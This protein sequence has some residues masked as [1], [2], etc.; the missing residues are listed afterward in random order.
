[1]PTLSFESRYAHFLLHGFLNFTFFVRENL[2][3]LNNMTVINI[4]GVLI[5][6]CVSDFGVPV[7]A[8]TR[9]SPVHRAEFLMPEATARRPV[10]VLVSSLSFLPSCYQFASCRGLHLSSRAAVLSL[11]SSI[12]FL[13]GKFRMLFSSLPM[14]NFVT[15]AIRGL[16]AAVTLVTDMP[17]STFFPQELA[18]RPIS[19]YG[20]RPVISKP[21]PAQWK[22]NLQRLIVDLPA[23][24]ITSF[25]LPE[26]LFY[27][28][29]FWRERRNKPIGYKIFL[30]YHYTISSISGQEWL[31]V[32][33]SS[34][35]IRHSQWLEPCHCAGYISQQSGCPRAIYRHHFMFSA[36]QNTV[37]SLQVMSF[38]RP[39]HASG[40]SIRRRSSALHGRQPTHTPV[41]SFSRSQ[42]GGTGHRSCQVSRYL[43]S[44]RVS[45]LLL[46]VG[47]CVSYCL[48]SWLPGYHFQM[49][50]I[51]P[52]VL[53]VL[54]R[55][56][57]T[58]SVSDIKT[59]HHIFTAMAY[60]P[61]GL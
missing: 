9:I 15:V 8:R 37:T 4:R 49:P 55:A 10:S 19:P 30:Y 44:E 35:V 46:R 45:R 13:S 21:S 6:F 36:H 18:L 17:S 38:A 57:L 27:Y 20:Y 39:T 48:F 42:W 7:H 12:F 59:H 56:A 5:I 29:Y 11:V 40:S 33:F 32:I 61:L 43:F 2:L 53:S 41:C 25:W 24:T 58:M 60:T 47:Q 3:V 51:F 50:A 28:T 26:R 14:S 16:L 22:F 31:S 52:A 23:R 1:M 54:A 34:P